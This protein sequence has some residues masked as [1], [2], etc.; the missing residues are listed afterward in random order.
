MQKD[1]GVI[2]EQDRVLVLRIGRGSEIYV[3]AE[4]PLETFAPR[5]G[6]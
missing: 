4:V 1:A 3:E 5:T 2:Q 6:R